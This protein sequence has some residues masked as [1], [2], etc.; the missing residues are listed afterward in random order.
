MANTKK[1]SYVAPIVV[2]VLLVVYFCLLMGV[3]FI[4]FFPIGVKIGAAVIILPLIGVSIFVLWERVKE[5]RSGELS[6]LSKY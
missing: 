6:D 1:G 5:L 4:P 3:C 2:T